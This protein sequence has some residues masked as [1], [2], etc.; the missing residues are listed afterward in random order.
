M[1][2]VYNFEQYAPPVID[3]S[4]LRAEGERRKTQR[5]TMLLALASLLSL[6]AL[7][8]FGLLA[9]GMYPL[10]C[11]LCFGYVVFAVT[12][13]SVIALVFAGREHV[14]A[15]AGDEQSES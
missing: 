9:G 4:M 5:Q 3:E 7:T 14:F 10:L 2:Q 1:K 8:V 13:G 6:A 15:L 12:G 11:G